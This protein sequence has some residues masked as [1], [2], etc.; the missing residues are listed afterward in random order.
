MIGSDRVPAPA[1]IFQGYQN[2]DDSSSRDDSASRINLQEGSK[3]GCASATCIGS[4]KICVSLKARQRLPSL[5]N[6]SGIIIGATKSSFRKLFYRYIYPFS[7][8]SNVFRK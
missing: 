3:E 5:K 2:Y 8:H 7:P 1:G 6:S 4:Q